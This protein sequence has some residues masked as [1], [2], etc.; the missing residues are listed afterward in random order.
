[1]HPTSSRRARA[2]ASRMRGNC[3]WKPLSVDLVNGGTP[4]SRSG[5]SRDVVRRSYTIVT[6]KL[7]W[8]DNVAIAPAWLPDTRTD[9]DTPIFRRAAEV[10]DEFV[11]KLERMSKAKASTVSSHGEQ[12]E[13]P[14]C[15]A[16]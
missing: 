15:S 2:V 11:P 4:R 5:A 8:H 14:S 16:T 1:M 3:T 6:A 7:R 10:V 12:T 13:V 9:R